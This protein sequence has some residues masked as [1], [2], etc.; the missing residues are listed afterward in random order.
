[1]G[2]A[3]KWGEGFF[4]RSVVSFRRR[5]VEEDIFCGF[6]WVL[7]GG[8]LVVVERSWSG[9]GVDKA[10]SR[11]RMTFLEVRYTGV[12]VQGYNQYNYSMLCNN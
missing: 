5:R 7:I 3:V 4:W 12:E 11:L 2:A 10:K 1:M 6:L 9:V 8:G